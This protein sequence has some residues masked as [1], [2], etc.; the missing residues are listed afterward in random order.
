MYKKLMPLVGKHFSYLGIDWILI[1]ILPEQ[2]SLVLRRVGKASQVQSNQ[3]GA[4]SR[5]SKETITLKISDT[6]NGYTEE[7]TTLL[8]GIVK[9]P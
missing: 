1:D 8:S 4:A 9:T 6:E 2:D 3:Y 5:M 7:I